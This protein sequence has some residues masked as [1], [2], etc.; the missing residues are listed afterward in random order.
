MKIFVIISLICFYSVKY[1]SA[2]FF[3]LYFEFKQ[4]TNAMIFCILNSFLNRMWFLVGPIIS[5]NYLMVGLNA[6]FCINVVYINKCKN[7]IMHWIPH[8][9]T[10][11]FNLYPNHFF[12]R[13]TKSVVKRLNTRFSYENFVLYSPIWFFYLD[14]G[15]AP[16]IRLPLK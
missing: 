3:C 7:R 5:L 1:R 8:L 13:G 12:R 14:W 6:K 15:G 9:Y 16:P 11:F 10:T 4:L 2:N